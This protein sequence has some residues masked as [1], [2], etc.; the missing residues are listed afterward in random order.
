MGEKK[1][2]GHVA[3]PAL[4]YW[5]RVQAVSASMKFGHTDVST[6]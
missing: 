2:P 1:K 6:T 4:W 5:F 3:A